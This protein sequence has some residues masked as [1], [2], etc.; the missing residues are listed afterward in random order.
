MV[1]KGVVGELFIGGAGV[2]KG[3]HNK[4]AITDERFIHHSRFGR[5]YRTGDLV[6]YTADGKLTYIGRTDFQVKL[7]GYRI[8]LGEIEKVLSTHPLIKESVVVV[9]DSTLIAYFVSKSKVSDTTELRLYAE[10]KLP[11]YMVPNHFVSLESFPLTLNGKINRKALPKPVLESNQHMSKQPQ[12][13]KEAKLVQIWKKILR[14]EEISTTDRFFELGGDSI[15]SLQ[16]IAEAKSAGLEISPKH[17]FTHPTIEKMAQIASGRER[18]QINQGLVT[19]NV[20]ITPIQEWFFHQEIPNK[21]NWNQSMILTLNH[22]IEPLVLQKA[23]QKLLFLHDGLRTRFYQKEAVWSAESTLQDDNFF[24]QVSNEEEADLASIHQKTESQI[25]ITNGP[26]LAATYIKQQ[27]SSPLL[28]LA[29]HH[30]V[31]D[32]VSWRIL[33]DDLGSLYR[34]I[35]SEKDLILPEKTT[36]YQKWSQYIQGN[37]ANVNQ[38]KKKWLEMI[39]KPTNAFPV[40]YPDGVNTDTQ[41]EEYRQEISALTTTAILEQSSQVKMNEL[42]IACL[43]KAYQRWSGEESLRLDLEGHGR[44]HQRD[45]MDLSRTIGWF[46]SI[47]PVVLQKDV[48][49]DSIQIVKDELRQ[50]PNGGSGFGQ[51]RYIQKDADMM[52]AP[53][54]PII[55][56][57]L[58]HF[59]QMIN[60]EHGVVKQLSFYGPRKYQEVERPYL[61]E[62]NSFIQA[63]KLIVLWG[64][65]KALYHPDTIARFAKY[66]EEECQLFVQQQKR[67]SKN[68]KKMKN[69]DMS[70]LFSKMN[71]RKDR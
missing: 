47:Y 14:R 38:E 29:I 39:N 42:L 60:G 59:D 68:Q 1:P 64:Y 35:E 57:Y 40:D 15:L 5:I 61:L 3:Y 12:N 67:K 56:N 21:N 33:L 23:L 55:F 37:T 30:L 9:Q 11:V 65:S 45:D 24:F 20:P 70:R 31:V 44:D 46:T 32:G 62:I 41:V 52:T 8:E 34:Q 58:G 18:N 69:A 36:S 43:W 26:L 10:S 4:E 51:L 66:V 49:R 27:E 71:Q 54:S 6:R 7:R 48:R 50:I 17:F 28:V 53:P 13:E 19:G 63:G 22:D 25:D 2:A 16:V